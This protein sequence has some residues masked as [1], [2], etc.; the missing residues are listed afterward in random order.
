MPTT[1]SQNLTIPANVV[2]GGTV[3]ATDVTTLYNTL[4]AFSVPD[5]VVT[6]LTSLYSTDSA[7]V[8]NGPATSTS[9]SGNYVDNTISSAASKTILHF[10][11]YSWQ[12]TAVTGGFTLTF[13]K[14][15]AA[16]ATTPGISASTAGSGMYFVLTGPHDSTI[17]RP[18]MGWTAVGT[19]TT[20][21]QF[22]GNADLTN[23]NWTSIGVQLGV[24][25][26][27]ATAFSLGHVRV[28]QG[29]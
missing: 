17:V 24:A 16:Y 18:V 6:L 3:Q 14:N 2:T 8:L 5:S 11:T 9:T 19:S 23:V 21:L 13:R 10:G 15:G 25:T 4:N 22:A 12:S 28:W 27:T 1:I 7:H 20:I 26:S 29:P